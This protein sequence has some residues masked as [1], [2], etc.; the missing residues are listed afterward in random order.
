M[1]A[2]TALPIPSASL[3]N[4]SN[5]PIAWARLANLRANLLS[6]SSAIISTAWVWVRN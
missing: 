2:P 4:C 3:A 1:T 6:N 5:S